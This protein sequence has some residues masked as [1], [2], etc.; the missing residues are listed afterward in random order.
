MNVSR[1]DFVLGSSVM[2][3]SLMGLRSALAGSVLSPVRPMFAALD[4]TSS[5]YLALPKGFGCTVISRTGDSMIDGLVV[6]G[7]PDGMAAFS[8]K[9]GLTAIIRNHEN[10][11]DY[12][13]QSPFGQY[14]TH[15]GKLDA[16]LLYDVG[17]S[18]PALGGCSTI[19]FDTK[20][21]R[22]V[23]Q[24]LSLAGTDRN[25]SG[26]ATSWGTWISSEESVE[27]AGSA[28]AVD[29]GYNFEV[30]PTLQSALSAP[31]ALKAMGRFRHEAVAED[32]TTGI[33]YQTEDRDDGAFYR[34]IPAQKHSLSAGGKLQALVVQ[35]AKGL[36]TRNWKTSTLRVGEKLR[37]DWLDVDNA[38]SPEDD[39]RKQAH[40]NGA[41]IFARAE[42]MCVVD[43]AVYFTATT[44][45]AGKLGQIWR[46][47]PDAKGGTLELFVETSERARLNN[48]DNMCFAP[49]GGMMVCED[50]KGQANRILHV[51]LQGNISVFA[52]NIFNDSELSGICFSPD[53]S[54][55][56]VNIQH[57]PGITLAI[58]GPWPRVAHGA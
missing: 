18:T 15:K 26:G 28:Y 29:H 55:L 56:F 52:E 23:R 40:S 37:C 14:L 44:G 10:Q 16:S 42:G 34:F 5:P 1:R 9:N 41:A 53:G 21:Q 25:C 20:K 24:F 39:L 13:D 54:T 22:V 51:D 17:A 19:I 2:L 48:P 33:F 27:R 12:Q 8:M 47:Q 50:G 3:L 30:K 38:Q 49:M 7:K 43:G 46:Y 32:A 57:D 11:I 58:S 36:D 31:V 6:P 35:D 4:R 45:G